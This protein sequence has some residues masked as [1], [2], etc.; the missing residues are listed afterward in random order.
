MAKFYGAIGFEGTTE[1][2]PGIWTEEI[3]ERFYY[4]DLLKNY[5]RLD[6]G[7]SINDNVTISNQV[8]I[9]A[10][11]YA[12]QNFHSIRY[13]AFMGIK[14]KVTSVDVEYPRLILSLGGV[15]NDTER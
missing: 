14:W 4:G 10:D 3:I 7:E 2:K 6:S 12:I 13:V 15:Y 8:S 9:I 1:T 5:R 11:P